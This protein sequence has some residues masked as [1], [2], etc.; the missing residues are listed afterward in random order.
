MGAAV[1]PDAQLE[2]QCQ[3]CHSNMSAVGS[4]ARQG[5]LDE[6]NCQACHTGTATHNNGQI[7][8]IDAY[9]PS[10]L[11]RVAVDQTYATNPDVPAP[12]YSLFKLSL[13]HGGL[14]CESCHGS[15][16]AEF[17]AT[18]PNDNLVMQGL[19]GHAGMAVECTSCHA[20]SP[21]TV[22]GGPHGMH[23]VGTTWISAHSNAVESGGLTQCKACHGADSHGTV[24][25]QSQANRSFATEFGTKSFF[26][27]STVSCYA[28]HNGPTSESPSPNHKP[29]AAAK[30]LTVGDTAASVTLTASDA[31]GDALTWRV[32]TQPPGGRVG[33][34]GNLATYDPDPGFAGIDDFTVA[35]WDGKVDSNLAH[36]TVTRLGN[37]SSYGAGYAGTG[38]VVPDFTAQGAPAVGGSFQVVLDNTS[39]VPGFGFV[40]V[41][42]E[43]AQI[44]TPYGGAFGLEPT[45]M[46]LLTLPAGGLA[47]PAA[48][49]NDPM[50]VGVVVL[51]QAVQAD[52]GATF[53]WAFS[54][55]LRLAL[56]P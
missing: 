26:D 14:R 13:G 16:H 41:S 8:Y 1:G 49:P 29:V 51:T 40:F 37:S 53:G 44:D 33:L 24:L 47:G 45:L 12:P 9:E 19:Q 6:P 25:S 34:V 2:M 42:L 27:G 36:V 17:P 56:G 39:G 5:W 54:R 48:I 30:V 3:S 22:T 55:G 23:P 52:P 4:T 10:G 46:L 21:T 38:G 15:T 35:A 18:H 31:D 50:L 11:L 7:Q 28:C 32:I 43:L 20:S